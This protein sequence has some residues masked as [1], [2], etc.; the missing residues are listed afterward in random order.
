MLKC[1]GDHFVNYS[2]DP[3]LIDILG[4]VKALLHP[5]LDR[6]LMSRHGLIDEGVVFHIIVGRLHI[7]GAIHALKA[8][9][10]EVW[11]L[12]AIRFDR[13]NLIWELPP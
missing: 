13:Y 3:L 6:P 1:V 12:F 11:Y 2:L 4:D 10:E 8:C 9:H 7:N 5:T